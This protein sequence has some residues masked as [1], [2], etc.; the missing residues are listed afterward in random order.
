[1]SD[2]KSFDRMS[3]RF[4]RP[5]APVENPGKSSAAITTQKKKRSR[6]SF[7]FADQSVRNLDEAYRKAEHDVYP[8][9]LN[10][11]HFIEALIAYG[12]QRIDE[13]VALALELQAEEEE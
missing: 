6:Q 9:K 5:P 2:S 1:M 12:I 3:Q 11:A 10:K 13:V 8:E 7:H 4:Q